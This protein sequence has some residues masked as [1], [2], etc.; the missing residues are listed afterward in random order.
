MKIRILLL[1]LACLLCTMLVNEAS[2]DTKTYYRDK[3]I[4]LMYHHIDKNEG[5]VT[6]SP[7][8]F[9]THMKLLHERGYNV[10]SMDQFYK[11][12]LHGGKV[13]ENAVLITF[14]DGY[15]SYRKYAV[16]IMDKYNMVGT[17]FIIGQSSDL[18]NV[19]TPHL[20]WDAMRELKEKGHSFYNHTYNLHD[21]GPLDKNGKKTGPLL[22]NRIYLKD[23]GRVETEKEYV[24]RITND[25]SKMEQ[26]LK[27][28]LDNDYG[29]MSFPFGAFNQTVKQVLKDMDVNLFI[30]IRPG[31]NKAGSDEVYRL[32]AGTPK[33]TAN[34]FV[35]L[36]RTYHD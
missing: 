25:L 11:F 24:A 35:E 10:I 27:E 30:T 9:G 12:M 23:K 26:R 33:M 36:L 14:D 2:A 8:R 21:Y 15:D 1:S 17:H 6:I 13:P 16:G 20:T 7:A 18:H 5:G 31:I 19:K 28:E 4:V 34:K 32:N 3:V 22:T 29:V